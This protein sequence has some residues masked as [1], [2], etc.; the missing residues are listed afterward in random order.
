MSVPSRCRYAVS[1]MI[2]FVG[3][4]GRSLLRTRPSAAIARACASIELM[5]VSIHR[6]CGTPTVR[7]ARNLAPMRLVSNAFVSRCGYRG[8]I[9]PGVVESGCAM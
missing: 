1:A 4:A 3:Q 9:E 2:S 8:M 5:A 7:S 6:R